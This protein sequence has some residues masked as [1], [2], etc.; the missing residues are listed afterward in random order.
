M[1]DRKF[2]LRTNLVNRAWTE[3]F[4][5]VEDEELRKFFDQEEKVIPLQQRV[6]YDELKVISDEISKTS[7]DKSN[8]T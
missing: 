7:V 8:S 2:L 4:Y 3:S 1:I 6:V 5:G